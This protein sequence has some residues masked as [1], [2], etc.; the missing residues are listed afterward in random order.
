MLR[1][2]ILL[3]FLLLS[4]SPAAQP[5]GTLDLGDKLLLAGDDSHGPAGGVQQFPAISAGDGAHLAAWED[6]R[7]A[8]SGL[9]TGEGTRDLFARR[10]GPNGQALDPVPFRVAGGFGRKRNVMAAWNGEHWLVTWWTKSPTPTFH[11]AEL[12]GARVDAAGNLV[13]TT[14][15]SIRKFDW[16]SVLLYTMASDG[17]GWGVVLQGTSAGEASVEAWR[18][19]A[20]GAV[21]QATPALFPTTSLVFGMRLAHD[22]TQYLFLWGDTSISARRYTDAFAPIGGTFTV[23]SGSAGNPELASDG[24]GWLVTWGKGGIGSQIQYRDVGPTGSMGSIVTVTSP[25]VL[26]YNLDPSVAWNGSGYTLVW[27]NGLFDPSH[28]R[29]ARISATGSLLDPEGLLLAQNDAPAQQGVSSL[30][31]G[32]AQVVWTDKLATPANTGD[33]SGA[34]I[35][36]VGVGPMLAV[37]SS[38]TR[39]GAPDLAAGGTGYMAVFTGDRDGSVAILAQRLDPA[40]GSLDAEP[41]EVA[42]GDVYGAPRVAWDGEHFLVVWEDRVVPSFVTDDRVLGRRIDAA[43]NFVDAAPFEILEGGT[44]DVAAIPGRFLVVARRADSTEIYRIYGMRLDGDQPLDA[45]QFEIGGNFARYPRAAGYSDRWLVAW[46]R[47]PTHDNPSASALARVVMSNGGTLPVQSLGGGS[48][49]DA[50]ASPDMGVVVWYANTDVQLRQIAP[51]GGVVGASTVVSAPEVQQG[52]SV[53]W[54][55]SEFVIAWE[56]L[57]DQAHFLDERRDI[58][59]RR[60]TES[61]TYLDA[62]LGVPVATSVDDDQLPVVAGRDGGFLIGWCSFEVEAPHAGVRVALRSGDAAL[63]ASYCGP[64]VPNSTGQPAVLVAVGSASVGANNVTLHAAQLPAHQF[65]YVVASQ[66]QGFVQNPGGAQGNL[67]LGGQILRFV[68][69]AQS[70]GPAG[71]LDA[72][73]DL[74]AFPSPYGGPVLAGQTW[75]FQVWYRDVNPGPTSNFTDGLSILFH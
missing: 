45:S 58:Y 49:P 16:S 14:P 2:L 57:R 44:P 36:P 33:V 9:G 65:G 75:N 71:E 31:D 38:T 63:G 24:S 56:D 29:Y 13:D 40:G 55:G 39:Q 54:S 19:D 7:V 23:A 53:G 35:E 25:S 10:I 59:A 18:V 50:G 6:H 21:S 46:Q 28:L 37:S 52:A 43:G 12:L 11:S 30:G 1:S 62:A 3:G 47:N 5:Q 22:G 8:F 64:A 74:S 34:R 73:L 15:I 70:S 26:Q 68:Q 42:A 67:C 48:A 69:L 60:M 72:V 66:A 61:G 20:S 32:N 51:T 27:T 41:I 4:T 17:D